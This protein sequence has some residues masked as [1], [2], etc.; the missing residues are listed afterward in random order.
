MS[1]DVKELR[2]TLEP[3]QRSL[4]RI[5]IALEAIAKVKNPE[6]KSKAE[7]DDELHRAG[8]YPTGR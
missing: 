8:K 5:A 7:L 3:L 1:I 4:E 6:F 2:V